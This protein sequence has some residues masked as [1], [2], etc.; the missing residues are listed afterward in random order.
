M[1]GVCKF[2]QY[3]FVDPLPSYRRM[4]HNSYII[5][6]VSD[7]L[8]RTICS[9]IL[10]FDAAGKV[11]LLL[12][13]PLALVNA[14]M[15]FPYGIGFYIPVFTDIGE[16]CLS[17]ITIPAQYHFHLIKHP[18]SNLHPHTWKTTFKTELV[19]CLIFLPRH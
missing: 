7:H 3:G 10:F 17:A 2:I 8:P 6:Q 15:N 18:P 14:L 9:S 11:R 16:N 4:E 13:A 19:D 1:L 12:Y 5:P